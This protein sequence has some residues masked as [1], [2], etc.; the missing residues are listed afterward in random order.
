MGAEAVVVARAGDGGAQERRVVVDALQDG[1]EDGEEDRVLGGVVAGVQ[2]VAPAVGDGPV[3]V[4]AGAVDA[5]EG[6]FVKEAD[7]AV[8]LGRLAQDLHD[9]HVVVAGEV[10]VL[11]ERRELELGGGDLVVA[12]LGW[13]AEA[14]EL[15]LDLGHEVEDARLDGAE[16][17]VLQLLVLGGRGA[18]DGAAGLD[19][20]GAAEVEVAVDQEVFLLGAERR[21][22]GPAWSGEA[23]SSCRARRRR[24][25]RRPSGCRASR[26]CRGV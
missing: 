2:E 20:V 17:V 6:L 10:D 4:L 26:H 7:K 21:R 8:A 14:P 22:P 3:V 5:V 19:E 18:E 12:R 23:A 16:V 11:E 13:D 25:C 9:K 1:A 24:S 15:V